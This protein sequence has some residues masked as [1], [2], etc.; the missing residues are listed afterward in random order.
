MSEV[1]SS[2]VAE[3][4]ISDRVFV[5]RLVIVIAFGAV[6][7]AAWYL[8]DVLLLMFG[9][10]L[11]AV[12]LRVIADLLTAYLHIPNRFSL[13]G[14]VLLVAG[15]IAVLVIGMGPELT[16]QI[17]G[18]FDR[19]PEAV[20]RATEALQIGSLMDLLK[21]ASD[22]SSIGNMV[23]RVFTWSTNIVGAVVA[24]V[25]VITGGIYLAADPD[26]YRRG[27]IML[28]PRDAKDSIAA[29]LDETGDALKSWLGGQ[30][31]AMTALGVLSAVGLWL[32]G[33]PSA[34]ALG[35]ILGLADFVPYIG[36][37]IA[38]VPVLL[39]ASTQDWQTLLWAVAVLVIAQ[40]V[41]NNLLIPLIASRVAS[42]APVV[43]LFAVVALGILFGP[44]GLLLGFPLAIV[45]DVAIRRLYIADTL[46]EPVEILGEPAE[47]SDASADADGSGLTG[48]A[49]RHRNRA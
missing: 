32:A 4:A 8:S 20:D 48:A 5:R 12:I 3:H 15:T 11:V 42:M 39:I 24:L 30:L 6:L 25:L 9:S 21:G 49:A 28:F 40:Q 33:V 46:G 14:A 34:L 37:M 17:R 18:V 1:Q 35:L 7:L 45:I 41:E 29:T 13:I 27:V 19:L 43:G 2:P 38:S 31:M 23:S 36:P 22:A 10:V 47:P 26:R 16:L 44:L